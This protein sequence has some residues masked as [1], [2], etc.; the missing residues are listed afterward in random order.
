MKT[1]TFTGHRP[2]KIRFENV[3]KSLLAE[4][5]TQYIIHKGCNVSDF[6]YIVGGCPGFDTIALQVLLGL[7]VPKDNIC[8]AL[9]YEG[10]EKLATNNPVVNE[11][12]RE[13]NMQ[14]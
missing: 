3:E 9:P 8:I 10:F 5:L 12:V 14:C 7:E 6:K 13:F 1:I 11:R 2:D 4:K